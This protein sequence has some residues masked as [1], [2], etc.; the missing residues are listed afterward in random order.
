MFNSY[1]TNYQRVNHL[2][3]YISIPYM[4]N[5]IWNRIKTILIMNMYKSYIWL[6]VSSHSKN[7]SLIGSSFPIYGKIKVMFQSPPAR[8]Y[9]V[10]SG[11]IRSTTQ[12]WWLKAQKSAACRVGRVGALGDGHSALR[13]LLKAKAAALRAAWRSPF[14]IFRGL[15]SKKNCQRLVSWSEL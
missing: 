13:A 12:K 1:V 3:T 14:K 5:T 15:K 8:S 7:M 11:E 4:E 2:K 10:D 9:M 6:V